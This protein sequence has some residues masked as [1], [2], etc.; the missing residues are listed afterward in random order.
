MEMLLLSRL[1]D[2]GR[3]LLDG[4]ITLREMFTDNPWDVIEEIREAECIL[5]GNQKFDARLFDEA[6]SLRVLAKQ[7]YRATE[8]IDHYAVDHQTDDSYN[9][10][11]NLTLYGKIE[12]QINGQQQQEAP[13]QR[14]SAL[15][16]Q[17]YLLYLF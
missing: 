12:R 6:S 3:K 7:A 14:M 15:A 4:K 5:I 16:M 11:R 10:K 9:I 2:A 13:Y 17:S 8:E 1:Y